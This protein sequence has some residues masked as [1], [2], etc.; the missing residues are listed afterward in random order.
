MAQ[1][2]QKVAEEVVEQTATPETAGGEAVVESISLVDLSSL[3]QIIDLASSRGAF[4]GAELEPVGALFNKLTAFLN[5]VKQAQEEAA[6]TN[7]G[8]AD[9]TDAEA[10]VE[11]SAGE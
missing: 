11:A 4:R 5:S 3:A 9:G 10:P 1:K 2:E 7:D 6:G 8:Q